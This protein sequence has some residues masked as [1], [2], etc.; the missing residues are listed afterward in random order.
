LNGH[1]RNTLIDGGEG[2]RGKRGERTM[3]CVVIKKRRSIVIEQA[4]LEDKA[5][6]GCLPLC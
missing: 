5:N 3:I 6:A 4:G 1:R 2:R